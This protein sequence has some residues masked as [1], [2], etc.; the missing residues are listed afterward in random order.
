MPTDNR[1]HAP[2]KSPTSPNRK[3]DDR[4]G[5]GKDGKAKYQDK[6]RAFGRR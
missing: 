1:N 4:G 5:Q 2:Q 3:R 6:S